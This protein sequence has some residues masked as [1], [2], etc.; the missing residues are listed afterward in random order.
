MTEAVRKAVSMQEPATIIVQT[1][2]PVGSS[3]LSTVLTFQMP[4]YP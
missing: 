4:L 1:V 2:L 3:T